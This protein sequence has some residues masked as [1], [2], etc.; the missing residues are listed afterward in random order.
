[1]RIQ[2][3]F[4]YSAGGKILTNGLFKN[5]KSRTFQ[6][7]TITDK[8][9]RDSLYMIIQKNVHYTKTRKPIKW[10]EALALTAFYNQQIPS[11][12]KLLTHQIDHIVPFSFQTQG[13]VDICRLGN[14]QLIPDSI[15]S[16]RRIK[17]ITD[18]WVSENKLLYQQYPSGEEYEKIYNGKLQREPYNAMCERRENMYI[19]HVISSY[20]Y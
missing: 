13:S 6:M 12:T 4:W 20:K 19:D 3:I 8:C 15:N 16:S 1:M 14:K 9:I 18:K 10:F 5:I 17:P 7:P 2:D 11:N